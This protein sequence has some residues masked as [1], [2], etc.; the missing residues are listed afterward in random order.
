MSRKTRNIP[1]RSKFIIITNGKESEK[2][3]FE[4]LRAFRHSIYEVKV[5]FVSGAPLSLLKRAIREKDGANQVWVVFDRDEFPADAIYTVMREAKK[6]NIGIA[7]SNV[8]F[9][10]WLIDHF[11]E[12]S[13]EKSARELTAILNKLLK[14]DNYQKGYNKNDRN[15]FDL[16]FLPR[17][18]EAVHN[19]KVSMQKRVAKFIETSPS[20]NNY[21]YCDW[22]SCT[23]VYKLIEALKLSDEK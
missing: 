18:D 19:A 10:V 11:R 2:N 8:A 7:F 3:Y 23:T 16:K 20:G 17:L 21:P 1:Q 9:E 22:N 13:N 15:V 14:D 12:F 4:S 6:N 5:E